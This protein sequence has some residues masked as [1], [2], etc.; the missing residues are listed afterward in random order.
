MFGKYQLTFALAGT[1]GLMVMLTSCFKDPQSPGYEY[2]PDMYR[3]AA[4]KTYEPNPNFADSSNALLPVAGTISRGEWPYDAN[5]VRDF[6]FPYPDTKEGY[7]AS[8]EM[9]NPVPFSEK[10][11]NEGQVLYINFCSHCHGV[12]GEGDGTLITNDKFPPPP[13]YSSGNSSRGGAMKDLSAGKIF[14]TIT[15]GI[16]LMGA[17]ASQLDK[18]Q[19]WKI[20]YYVQTLQGKTLGEGGSA[21]EPI[22]EETANAEVTE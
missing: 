3:S 14:H 4:Y 10:V 1:F 16:N 8:S 20:V 12:K 18:E 15:Y 17:H 6:P 9:A 19:R 11:L 21:E 7:E 13:S 2:M 5:E 22:E